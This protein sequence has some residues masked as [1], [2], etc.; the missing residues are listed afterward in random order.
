VDVGGPPG[1][2]ASAGCTGTSLR[3]KTQRRLEMQSA[4]DL[5]LT[6]NRPISR[7]LHAK[8]TAVQGSHHRIVVSRRRYGCSVA[9]AGTY[10]E[11]VLRNF[12]PGLPQGASP[13]GPLIRDDAGNLYGTTVS[14]GLYGAGTV[15]RIA[16]G[17]KETVLYSFTGGADGSEPQGGVVRDAAGN[18]YGTAFSG[19]STTGPGC[20]QFPGTPADGCGVVFK[21][22]P[23]GTEAVL[24]TFLDG[25]DDGLR[26]HRM[27]GRPSPA[28]LRRFAAWKYHQNLPEFQAIEIRRFQFGGRHPYIEVT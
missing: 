4:G 17:G 10:T 8:F 13:S 2:A 25:D 3:G 20:N 22:E 19:G 9:P 28:F 23:T 16:A 18:L 7:A 1:S 21:L 12:P 11:T 15:F 14:G 27:L 6:G 24:Y 26:K 5:L